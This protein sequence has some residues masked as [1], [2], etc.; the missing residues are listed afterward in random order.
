MHDYSKPC[1]RAIGTLQPPSRCTPRHARMVRTQQAAAVRSAG[2]CDAPHEGEQHARVGVCRYGYMCVCIH[3]TRGRA[4]DT[5]GCRSPRECARRPACG[6]ANVARCN[7]SRARDACLH[8]PSR[9]PHAARCL[10]LTALLPHAALDQLV[11]PTG[12][13]R[14]RGRA[15]RALRAARAAAAASSPRL[16]VQQLRLQL[17]RSAVQRAPQG[18]RRRAARGIGS[19]AV[20]QPHAR[21]RLARGDIAGAARACMRVRRVGV[22]CVRGR[23]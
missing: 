6:R 19:C 3:T 17:N 22:A 12:T 2:A 18:R 5:R 7:A 9:T 21:Q 13:P 11:A 15:A 8:A 4:A 10:A 20:A 14:R 1:A 23:V 16:A